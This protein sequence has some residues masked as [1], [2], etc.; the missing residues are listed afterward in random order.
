MYI[1]ENEARLQ[2]I[3]VMPVLVDDYVCQ[4]YNKKDTKQNKYKYVSLLF[5]MVHLRPRH[6]T[7]YPVR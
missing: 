4:R 7:M 6:L 1:C 3:T 5:R 2:Q